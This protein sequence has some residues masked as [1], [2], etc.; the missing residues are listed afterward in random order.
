MMTATARTVK[1][2]GHVGR[3]ATKLRRLY[4]C[5]PCW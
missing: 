4:P 5:L 3:P 2:K 1:T